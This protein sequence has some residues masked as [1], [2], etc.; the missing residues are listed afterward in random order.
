MQARGL[1]GARHIHKKVLELPI[2]KFD[3]EDPNHT[4]LAEIGEVCHEKVNQWI[5]NKGMGKVKSIG[6][7]RT[8]VREMLA[9]ELQ[10]IDEIVREI[11]MIR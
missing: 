8:M 9:N 1:W 4:R 7:M 3:P 2:P 6:K 5:E 11:I 10:K